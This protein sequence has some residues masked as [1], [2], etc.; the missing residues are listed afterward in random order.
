MRAFGFACLLCLVAAT[1]SHAQQVPGTVLPYRPITPLTT[2]ML[3]P[4][5]IHLMELEGE[6]QQAVAS[7]GGKAFASWFAEDGVTLSEGK[8]AVLGRAAIA[9][10]ATWTAEEYQL[11]WA[12]EGAQTSPAGDM[13]FTWG[14]YQGR[15]R[16]ANGQSVVTAGRYLTIWKKL[17]DGSWKVALESSAAAPPDP[18]ACCSVPPS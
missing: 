3:T 6:F 18:A 9:A 17:P 15:A 4:G 14:R 8:A 2:P 13:G 5:V 10:Q 7:G 16:G 11:T 1:P 12:P